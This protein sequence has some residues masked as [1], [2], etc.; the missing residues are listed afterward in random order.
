MLFIP[1]TLPSVGL[2]DIVSKKGAFLGHSKGHIELQ[3]TVV[4]MAL[5]ISCDQGSA[6][7]KSH[8]H[9]SSGN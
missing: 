9:I 5:W 2:E 7:K 4:A 6:G 3:A 8:H 1:A